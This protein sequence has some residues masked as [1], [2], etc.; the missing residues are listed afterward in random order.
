MNTIILAIAVVAWLSMIVLPLMEVRKRRRRD[1]ILAERLRQ[2]Q[3][4]NTETDVRQ[5]D[6]R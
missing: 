3:R 6:P 4:E 5:S 2:W 1:A